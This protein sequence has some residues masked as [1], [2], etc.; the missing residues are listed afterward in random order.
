VNQEIKP[1]IAQTLLTDFTRLEL[2]QDIFQQAID[3]LAEP[4]FVKDRR[5]RW[6]ICNEAICK[7]IGHPR[8]EILGKSD[9]DYSSPEQASV[10][11]Q[12]DVE[13]FNTGRPVMNEEV[14]TFPD[15]TLHTIYTRKYPLKDSTGKVIALSGFITDVTDLERK[16]EKINL[17]E[18]N[19]MKQM[20]TI[21]LQRLLLEQISTPI[22]EVWEHILL[23]PLIGIID[24]Y[25]AIRLTD[26]LLT[27]I[28]QTQARILIMDVTGVP[29]V[30]SSVAGH[31]LQSILAAR[32][33][34]CKCILVGIHPHVAQIMVEL[35][36]D[37]SQ[38]TTRATLC[39]GLKHAI[40]LLAN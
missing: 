26:S 22:L 40:A 9:F 14:I 21:E 34:G 38:I 6:I 8:E 16:Q 32:L 35:G 27:A 15:G 12:V 18:A 10:F 25:R 29:I 36:I 7:Q 20:D 39:E 13:V 23:L 5:H 28:N 11:W 31:L 17:L 1:E 3:A 2:S 30:D 19:V 33:L 37:F 24:S 4:F